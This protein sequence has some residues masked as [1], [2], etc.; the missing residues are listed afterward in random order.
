[1]KAANKA[2]QWVMYLYLTRKRGKKVK[3]VNMVRNA[4]TLFSFA[5]GVFL[6]IFVQNTMMS[7]ESNIVI[8]ST[9]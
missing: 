5:Y 9:Y 2:F 3:R 8:K 6:S 7:L 1:M 4:E